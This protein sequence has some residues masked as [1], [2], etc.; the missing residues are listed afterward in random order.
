MTGNLWP[1]LRSVL[2]V[3]LY[4][5]S[6]VCFVCLFFLEQITVSV[7][8]ERPLIL[9]SDAREMTEEACLLFFLREGFIS[10]PVSLKC[11]CLV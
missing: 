6:F 5:F 11:L 8:F 4:R 1:G 2:D 10:Q 3:G 9:G 7:L